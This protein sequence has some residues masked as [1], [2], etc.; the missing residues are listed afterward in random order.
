[1]ELVVKSVSPETLK[2]ATLVVAIGEGRKLGIA[3]KQVD[4]LSGGAISAVLK[5]GDLA[6]KV[7]Q[8]LLLHSLPNLKAERVLLVGVGKDEELGD[9]PF[10]K[11][12]A[13]ILNT[14]K[15]LGG[16]DAVLALD[17]VIVKGRD[18]YGKT[19]LLAETLVDGGYTFDQFKSQKAEPRALKK[20]TLLTIKA[21][22]AEVQ[23][24]VNHATAIANG[25]AFTRDLGNLPPNICHPTFMGEQAK[26]LGKE[27]KDLKVEVLDE[28]KIKS[29]GMGS[30]Y[31]VGQGSAQPPRLIVMQYNGGKKS[32]KPFSLVGKGITFDTGGISLKPGAGMDEMKYDMGG[33][34]SV[35]GTLRAVLELKLPINLV[36]ILACAENMPSGNASRPGDIVTT[37]SGQT[38]EILNTDA[39][40]RLV[41]CDALTYSERFKP[42]AVIDIATLTGACV[43]A[44]G[45]V[46]TGLFTQDDDLADSLLKAGR[47]SLDTAWRMPLEDAYQEQLKSNFAD[48]ANIGGPP[49][50]SVTAACFL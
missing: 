23:R 15:G 33:A 2:T 11:I 40:G 12:V 29:L 48:I 35:F 36:C 3:A 1:M 41:L 13:G 10:R 47:A 32:E 7:G 37:M 6:G 9:R 4:E 16:G 28:K 27:F 19:R 21:A 14:L 26:N 43:V 50:G 39:E 30:F 20:I 45:H 44:L 17:E 18:S 22:Q 38:V 46:N 49:A 24:A 31:A 8:S 5:R 25:M 42:Q 34:A